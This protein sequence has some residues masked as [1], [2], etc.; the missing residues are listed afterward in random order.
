MDVPAAVDGHSSVRNV[1]E[2]SRGDGA[3]AALRGAEQGCAGSR[4]RR[5]GLPYTS[6]REPPS[7]GKGSVAYDWISEALHT[8]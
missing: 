4:L 8:P 1:G 5:A 7:L 3:A 6:T 2:L